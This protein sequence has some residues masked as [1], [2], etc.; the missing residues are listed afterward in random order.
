MPLSR[1]TLL[2]ALLAAGPAGAACSVET[3]P[4]S[5]GTI[6]VLRTSSGN[7]EVVVRCDQP[8]GFTVGLSPGSGGSEGRQMD[9]PGSAAL[10]YALF[11][12]ASYTL[13]WGDG[14]AI[15]Q[16]RDGSSNGNAP[17]RLTI[18]GLIPRQP[19]TEPGTYTDSL[20]VTLTF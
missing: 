7:G 9:G 11:A 2:L 5:F 16:P 6:D 17:E 12:D 14:R 4:V 3:N 15:G 13:P 18:Y 20:Q 1:L 19:D 8:T 10:A